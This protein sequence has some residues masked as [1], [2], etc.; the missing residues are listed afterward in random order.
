MEAFTNFYSPPMSDQAASWLQALLLWRLS[1]R[2]MLVVQAAGRED[3]DFNDCPATN[4]YIFAVNSNRI[5]DIKE[6][7]LR[8]APGLA[9]YD[10]KT[11]AGVRGSTVSC[12]PNVGN[13]MR[14]K[15]L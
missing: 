2:A 4:R 11:R 7:A 14:V 5:R 3:M 1:L 10:P 13:M 8:L 6:S 9:V 15:L 12:G